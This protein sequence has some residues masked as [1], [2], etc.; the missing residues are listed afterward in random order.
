MSSHQQYVN[1]LAG[2]I[3]KFPSGGGPK[4]DG[5]KVMWRGKRRIPIA[6]AIEFSD[7]STIPKQAAVIVLGIQLG[8]K[9]AVAASDLLAKGVTLHFGWN[10]SFQHSAELGAFLLSCLIKTKMYRLQE[11]GKGGEKW[12]RVRDKAVLEFSE[13]DIYT[14]HKPFPHWTGLDDEEGRQL[15]THSYPQLDKTKWHPE[16]HHFFGTGW[17]EKQQEMTLP[18]YRLTAKDKKERSQP[19]LWVKFRSHLM[20]VLDLIVCFQNLMEKRCKVIGNYIFIIEIILVVKLSSLNG[21]FRS[22]M[23]TV[24]H[25]IHLQSNQVQSIM[26]ESFLMRVEL[27][28][29]N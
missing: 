25:P 7:E 20:I 2:V 13:R 12:I 23:T 1:K 15:V 5:Q 21:S 14:A 16:P 9:K 29:K 22:L 11:F 24:R 19:N 28:E 10:L 3:R 17:D 18:E 27:P 4:F 26:A 8:N 6:D